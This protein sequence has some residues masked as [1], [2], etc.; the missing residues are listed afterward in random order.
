MNI[1]V[2]PGDPNNCVNINGSGTI[3]VA[4]L[5][6]SSFPVSKV[7]PSSLVLD[8]LT[9][10]ADPADER[11]GMACQ[12]KISREGFHDTKHDHSPCTDDH[13]SAGANRLCGNC[14]LSRAKTTVSRPFSDA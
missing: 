12:S 14:L 13:A 4:V 10:L 11:N 6:S 9:E 8:G 2:K 7:D 3:P 1:D 5:G